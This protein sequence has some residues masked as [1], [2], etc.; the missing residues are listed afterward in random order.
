MNQE[1]LLSF[2]LV[3]QM[4]CLLLLGGWLNQA[5]AWSPEI[6]SA[7]QS[8][9]KGNSVEAQLKFEQVVAAPKKILEES[10]IALFY[11]A[12]I[13]S[14]LDE[15]GNDRVEK[16][17][18]QLLSSSQDFN[19]DDPRFK[20]VISKDDIPSDFKK[21]YDGLKTQNLCLPLSSYES[22]VQK[23]LVDKNCDRVDQLLVKWETL[24]PESSPKL[25]EIK[26]TRKTL[27]SLKGMGQ[28][29]SN[30]PSPEQ[31]PPPP[32]TSC[33]V[34]RFHVENLVTQ[35]CQPLLKAKRYIAI[36]PTKTI[37]DT[38]LEC[39]QKAQKLCPDEPKVLE[40]FA[41]MEKFYVKKT[42]T[43]LQAGQRDKAKNF[44][45]NLKAVNPQ[46]TAIEDFELKL[47]QLQ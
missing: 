43:A 45:D 15:T 32:P 26:K 36:G 46:S 27:Q 39:Y 41:D 9:I 5:L 10:Q 6:T 24:L 14:K 4:T 31:P 8:Y 25:E 35:T 28:C 21:T 19:P 33:G 16:L 11:L 44:L 17:L 2:T 23:A 22:G 18:C 34:I 3:T 20:E 37:A 12:L 30:E 13:G 40:G 38:A 1:K 47:Q 29:S 7:I 42:N